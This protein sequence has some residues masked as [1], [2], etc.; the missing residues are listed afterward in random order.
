VDNGTQVSP[1]YDPMLAKLIVHAPTRDDALRSLAQV[2]AQTVVY[3][4]QT[5]LAYL[6]YLLTLPEVIDGRI[7][8][9]SLSCVAYKEA[10]LDVLAAG[11]LTTIQDAPGRVGYWD[12]GVP[13]SGPFDSRAFGLGNRLLNNLESAAGLEITL[14]GP[15]VQFNWDCSFVVTG[16]S[17]PVLLDEVVMPMWQVCHARAGQVL[18]LGKLSQEGCRAYLLVAGGIDC[19]LYLG[20]R[21]TFTL[22]QFGGHAGRQLRAG[23]VLHLA[24]PALASEQS[25]PKTLI[26]SYG[27]EWQIRVMYGPHGSPEFFTD[28]DITAFFAAS[29]QVHYNSSRTG[30]RLIGPKPTW[31]RT[32]GG[33]AGLH[34]SNIHD[35]AHACDFRP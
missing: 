5:N 15:T 19:P 14:S 35:N 22:G 13:P 6:Q 11:A 9:A 1:F 27:R 29:W 7:I 18:Q 3:G 28:S 10:T 34:P 20:S 8:T 31:A 16:A 24:A 17:L 26:P 33:E 12:V 32:D 25:L 4:I 21:S 30:I 23:D 2:L